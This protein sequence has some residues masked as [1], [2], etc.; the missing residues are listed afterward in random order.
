MAISF[1]FQ[2]PDEESYLRRHRKYEKEE[3]K[4]KNREKEKLQ[5]EMYQQ[6]QF[7]ERVRQTDKNII[8]SIATSL[9]QQRGQDP[10]PQIDPDA[11]R[12]RILADAEDQLNRFEQLGFSL[13]SRK[14][15]TADEDHHH[16]PIL[17]PPPPPPPP[18]TTTTTT[19]TMAPTIIPT[20]TPLTTTAPSSSPN[21]P[22]SPPRSRPPSS[23]ASTKHPRTT[24]SSVSH[25]PSSSSASPVKASPP[26]PPPEPEQPEQNEQGQGTD[27]VPQNHVSLEGAPLPKVEGTAMVAGPEDVAPSGPGRVASPAREPFRSFY[28]RPNAVH[29][30]NA[31]RGHR[32]SHR[33]LV[34]FGCKVPPI[35]E[36]EFH[37]PHDPFGAWMDDRVRHHKRRKP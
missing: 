23:T 35:P 21:I 30:K 34:A 15:T 14:K 2:A 13:S 37:L 5:H 10:P 29:V 9:L 19:A 32:R 17:T 1:C 26:L 33:H 25:L 27:K 22:V 31:A 7:V 20:T 36:C 6:Q 16:H 3:K 8:M 18:T 24:P 11:L 4:V 28:D 12:R